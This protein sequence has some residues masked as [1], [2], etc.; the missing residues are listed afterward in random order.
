MNDFK[1]TAHYPIDLG[2]LPK[3][4]SV[5]FVGALCTDVQAGFAS[6]EHNSA[7]T[8]I[9][10]LRP[11]NIDREG[12]L[13][14]STIKS[15]ASRIDGRRLQQG[16]VL[17]N[18][19]NSPV[20]VGKTAAVSLNHE[21]AFSNHMTRV[22]ASEGIDY[23]F[24]AYHLHYLWMS[25]YFLRRCSH[26]VNQASVSSDTLASSVPVTVA[27]TAEQVRIVETIDSH[28]SYLDAALKS[29]ERAQVKLKTYRASVLKA[30]IEGRLVPTE[31]ELAR[32]EERPYEPAE[33]LLT[34]ML[35]ERRRRWEK[36]EF[37]RMKAKGNTPNDNKWRAKYKEPAAPVSSKLP[38]LP[39][40]W[41]WASVDQV[42]D[43]LLGRQR[44]PQYLTGK[45]FRPYLRV[46]NIKDDHIE[47]A[48]IEEMDFDKT[49]FAKYR[50][51]P[52]DILVSEG[53]SPHLVGQSAIYRG[54]VDGLCF[55]K[56]LHRF[57]PIEHGPSAE[58]AQLVFRA[59]VRMRV[60]QEVA[61]IT[62]NIAHLT[63]VKFK[64][65]RFPLPPLSEQERIVAEAQRLLS[66]A[67]AVDQQVQFE[68][69]RLMRLRQAI[70]KSAFEGNL[71]DQRPG[72]EPAEKL[73]AR[74]RAGRA[75]SVPRKKARARSLKAAS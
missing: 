30:A 4:W 39:E 34:R 41:C 73:L 42:G 18:N 26:H 33:A 11:M 37:A 35:T 22:R 69:T 75:T 64:E 19:T 60:F 29:L 15:V 49:H 23:R 3:G 57:R 45:R 8:G 61:S 38:K 28:F 68:R 25:G 24:L 36:T 56:T 6:G 48:D 7:G 51:Q 72:D 50:L 52:G 14:L 58:F 46:A 1:D 17:F 44:A 27:P 53:Q 10:H 63:L 12:R 71:V 31:A 47:L 67:D 55:Q 9:P 54:G 66:V 65:S 32:K 21:F 2:N 13:N 74:I 40:G 5:A 59:H 16:D 43:V 20:L 70:L 62:T